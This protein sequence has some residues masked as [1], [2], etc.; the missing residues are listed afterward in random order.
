LGV[1]LLN[2][3]TEIGVDLLGIIY[4]YDSGNNYIRI[5]DNNGDV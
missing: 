5:I 4:F 1:S 2:E 3:P